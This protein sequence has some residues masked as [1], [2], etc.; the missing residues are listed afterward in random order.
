MGRDTHLQSLFYVS[1]TVPSKGALPPGAL[2]RAHTKNHSTSRAAF[3]HISKSP[4]R[5]EFM[6]GWV[7][8]DM[9]QYILPWQT[10][11][12]LRLLRLRSSCIQVDTVYLA[13][14][15]IVKIN[16]SRSISR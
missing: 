13:F 1:F 11:S 12:L 8:L 14:R 15:V 9:D 16:S 7:L 3:N 5:V 10:C 2:H 6:G 4:I